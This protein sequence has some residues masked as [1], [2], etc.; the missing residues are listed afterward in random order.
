MYGIIYN[1]SGYK[2]VI[3]ENDSSY[4]LLDVN[5]QPAYIPNNADETYEYMRSKQFGFGFP[6]TIEP[7]YVPGHPRVR[8]RD[9]VPESEIERI[10]NVEQNPMRE[11]YVKTFLTFVNQM[12]YN[13]PRVA[14]IGAINMVLSYG[15]LPHKLKRYREHLLSF[16]ETITF[17]RTSRM[18]QPWLAYFSHHTFP[19]NFADMTSLLESRYRA[20]NIGYNWVDRL[21]YLESDSDVNEP[22]PRPP[23]PPSQSP[24]TSYESMDM[25]NSLI[26]GV[27]S[28]TRVVGSIAY[29]EKDEKEYAYKIIYFK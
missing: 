19:S 28:N 15:I 6:T 17:T 2:I 23:Q 22:P 9:R 11:S 26:S 16:P 10:Y 29:P 24:D 18:A 3:D 5:T 27:D 14:T 8:G 7:S 13:A 25:S 21:K 20:K 4:E 1:H 12:F